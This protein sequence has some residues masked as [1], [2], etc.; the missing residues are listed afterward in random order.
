MPGRDPTA[1]SVAGQVRRLR[2]Y[3]PSRPVARDLRP[4]SPLRLR[5]RRG[6]RSQLVHLPL[7]ERG[8]GGNERLRDG[9]HR[10]PRRLRLLD[11]SL[12]VRGGVL[13]V[14]DVD[15]DLVGGDLSVDRGL[16]RGDRLDPLTDGLE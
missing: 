1:R 6:E 9:R 12:D 2:P 3:V 13:T 8:A 4:S 10:D 7:L 11:L 5:E 16:V 15:L 14:V